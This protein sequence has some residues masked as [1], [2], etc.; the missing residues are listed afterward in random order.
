ME[1]MGQPQKRSMKYV[2]LAFTL[3]SACTWEG[4][5]FTSLLSPPSASS[6]GAIAPNGT[7]AGLGLIC[8]DENGTKNS[9]YL[10]SDGSPSETVT[11]TEGLY[12]IV[13]ES[14][15]C[16][17]TFSGIYQIIS[18]QT[19]TSL[20]FQNS[21]GVSPSSSCNI[22]FTFSRENMSDPE[23]PNSA[24]RQNFTD[25]SATITRS[26]KMI[27][28]PEKR[29]LYL[30]TDYTNGPKEQCYVAYLKK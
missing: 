30:S 11:L 14:T 9:S 6:K 27:Y 18:P 5:K 25:S 15:T 2:A 3:L 21:V 24:F 26:L 29:V 8:L 19:G 22:H 16:K 12:E 1:D 13:N 17:A 4:G 20:F 10:F 7:Y 28:D 23:I